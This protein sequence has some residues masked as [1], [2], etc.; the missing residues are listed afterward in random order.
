MRGVKG[1]R[2]ERLVIPSWQTPEFPWPFFEK[3]RWAMRGGKSS[4]RIT[5][6]G[7]RRRHRWSTGLAKSY[8]EWTKIKKREGNERKF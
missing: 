5:F 2:R 1:G 7:K 4:R 8:R 6:S 3:R